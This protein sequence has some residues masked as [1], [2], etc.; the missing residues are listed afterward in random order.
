MIIGGRE[1]KNMN[2]IFDAIL[3]LLKTTGMQVVILLCL[4]FLLPVIPFIFSSSVAGSHLFNGFQIVI[5]V[6]STFGIPYYLLRK[7]Y[8]NITIRIIG[9]IVTLIPAGFI[10]FTIL[11]NVS[12]LFPIVKTIEF[13]PISDAE[14]RETLSQEYQDL[15]NCLPNHWEV[16]E[17]SI[18]NNSNWAYVSSAQG[19]RIKVYGTETGT[20]TYFSSSG[21]TRTDTLYNEA[22]TF[23]LMDGKFNPNWGYL[24]QLFSGFRLVP[25]EL[26][27]EI[28]NDD[29]CKVYAEESITILPKNKERENTTPDGFI[30]AHGAEMPRDGGSWKNWRNDIKNCFRTKGY[31]TR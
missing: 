4:F 29:K 19:I 18:I 12:F 5:A 10:T 28:V 31:R 6:F 23:Y 25:I 26:P 15:L 27:Y 30:G 17:D 14:F 13:A 8:L 2:K 3:F 9:S 22:R 16:L 1:K 20:R 7:E 24:N 21:E 11:A